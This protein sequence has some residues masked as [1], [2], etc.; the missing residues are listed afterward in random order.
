MSWEE[1]GPELGSA[2][3]GLRLHGLEGCRATLAGA[4]LRGGASSLPFL[5]AGL[6][7]E[8][9]AKPLSE[10]LRKNLGISKDSAREGEVG[11]EIKSSPVF[12]RGDNSLLGQ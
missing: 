12:M 3:G 11:E 7:Q 8:L 9:S 2:L 4:L 6:L 10:P 5:R 1:A